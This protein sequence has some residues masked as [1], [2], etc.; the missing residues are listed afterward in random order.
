MI[1][2]N[3]RIPARAL[4]TAFVLV[5]GLEAS[6]ADVLTDRQSRALEQVCAQCHLAPGLGVPMLG[7]DRAWETR[8]QKGLEVL[9]HNTVVGLGNMPPLGT[10]GFC[11]E[12]DLRALAAFMAGMPAAHASEGDR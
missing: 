4:A 11:T 12:A 10:C 6:A 1:R 2:A 5:A 3:G 8:R 9:V 7:D